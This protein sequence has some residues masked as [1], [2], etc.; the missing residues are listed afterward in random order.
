MGLKED[1]LEQLKEVERLAQTSR[2]GRLLHHPYRYLS[3]ILFKD[4]IYPRSRK[5]KEKRTRLFNGRE[6]TI[7]LPSST[8][9]YLTGGKSHDSEIRLARFLI[10]NLE[11]GQHFLDIGAHYGYFSLIASDLTGPSGKVLALEPAGRTHAILSRNCTGSSNITVIRKA[12][13]DEPGEITFYEFPNL[14][15]EYNAIDIEQFKEEKW[16][17]GFK[18]QQTVVPATTVNELTSDGFRPAIIKIDVE[19]AELKV[20]KGGL[21][22]FEQNSPMIAMEYLA[23]ERD[24]TGHRNAVTMLRQKGYK[25]FLLDRQGGLQETDDI[26][27]HLHRE[28]TASDNIILS[29]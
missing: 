2:A 29:K 13:A 27:G 12:I 6:M 4:F 15:S 18:P 19:G 20:I 8:D 17:A 16:F 25:T 3:A 10:R 24:N 23:P 1:M 28:K 9:I 5:E 22:F 26:E 14:F 11:P 21:T 7:V